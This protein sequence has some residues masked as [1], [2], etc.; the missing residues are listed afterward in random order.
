LRYLQRP[1]K[2]KIIDPNNYETNGG[3]ALDSA[4][5]ENMNDIDIYVQTI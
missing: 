5:F 3:E 1:I 4:S 2:I